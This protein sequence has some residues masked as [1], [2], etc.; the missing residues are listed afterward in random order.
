MRIVIVEDE[1]SAKDYLIQLIK[2][3]DPFFEIVKTLD[4]VKASVNYLSNSNEFDLIFMDINLADGNAFTIFNQITITK[5]IIFTT[6]YEGFA[7]KAFE[8]NSID[9]LLKPIQKQSVL[10]AVKKYKS[11]H[12][13]NGF[14]TDQLRSVIKS[15]ENYRKTYKTCFLIPQRDE[16]I[17]VETEFISYF[18]IEKRLV[19]VMTIYNKEYTMNL[20]LDELE[21]QLNPNDFFRVNRQFLIHRR[22]VKNLYTYFGGKLIIKT[23]TLLN[24]KIVVSKVK[25]RIFKD[26]MRY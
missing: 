22:S 4:T 17:P 3:I 7:I 19:K 18:Y 10:K 11:L 23:N 21:H 16:L 6:A 1:E 14:N 20:N 9:Y 12:N 13:Q 25:A 5:P 2:S 24:K 26:W 15:I 8:V